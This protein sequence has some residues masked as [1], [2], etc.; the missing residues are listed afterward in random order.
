[1]HQH[2]ISNI[3][4]FIEVINCN[5][6]S[7]AAKKLGLSKPSVSR[8][9]NELEIYLKTQLIKRTTRKLSL[10]ESGK[11]L[12]ER[13]QNFDS[14]ITTV[15]QEITELNDRP[16]GT[17]QIAFSSYLS[18]DV[19]INKIIADFMLAYPGISIELQSFTSSN[20]IDLIQKK[21]HLYFTDNDMTSA[22]LK[23]ELLLTYPIKLC[24]SP[25]YLQAHGQPQ[26]PN[27]LRDHNC[28]LH[29]LYEK[30]ITDWE[31]NVDG[32]IR[33]ISVKGNLHSSRTHFLVRL[34]S[35]FSCVSQLV[36]TYVVVK[37]TYRMDCAANDVAVEANMN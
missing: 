23:S 17:L 1:M 34:I 19:K 35:Q 7:G 11:L 30:P 3:S 9:V 12:Y 16:K 32:A 18:N 15:L 27:D 37:L 10:T 36:T 22:S 24:A 29:Y 25:S 8:R 31:I 20:D 28:L 13:C 33:N 5:S 14:T 26:H 2:V 21:F 4:L 6:F